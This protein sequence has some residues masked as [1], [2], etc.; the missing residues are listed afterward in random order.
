MVVAGVIRDAGGRILVTRRPEGRH[1]AGLWEFPGGKVHPHEHPEQAL[2]RELREE[3]GIDVTVAAPVTFGVHD[4]R[5]RRIILLFYEARISGGEPK[6]LDGQEIRWV[7][8]EQLGRLST[9]PADARL[10]LKL[11]EERPPGSF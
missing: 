10:I 1:M 9:P 3:L 4:E 2:I 11:Q 8:P 7:T 6:P 5:E